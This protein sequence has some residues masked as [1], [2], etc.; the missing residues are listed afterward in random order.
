[1]T[2]EDVQAR[3]ST[4]AVLKTFERIKLSNLP[5][6]VRM[7]YEAEVEQDSKLD[8][9]LAN[10]KAFARNMLHLN[11]PIATIMEMTGLTKEQMDLLNMK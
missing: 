8:G 4:P 6:D 7:A 9:P 5:D 1:M 11:I 3:I 2:E 10:K